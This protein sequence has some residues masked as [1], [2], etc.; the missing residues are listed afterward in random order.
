MQIVG[1]PMGNIKRLI[2]LNLFSM[3]KADLVAAIAAEAGLTKVQAQG[4]LE[5]TV[6]AISEALQKGESVQLVGFGTFSVVEKAARQGVNPATG[7]KIEIAAKKV[8]KFKAGKGLA[9]QLVYDIQRVAS[10]EQ[11]VLCPT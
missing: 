3:N 11:L 1:P 6:K 4:A 8:A 5:A 7:A 2:N 9:L 10:K